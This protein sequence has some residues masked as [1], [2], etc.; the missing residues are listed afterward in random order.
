MLAHVRCCQHHPK[1]GRINPGT[2]CAPYL[3]S[4]CP[5]EGSDT[6]FHGQIVSHLCRSLSFRAQAGCRPAGG[7]RILSTASVKLPDSKESLAKELQALKVAAGDLAEAGTIA[8][9]PALQLETWP[10][11]LCWPC[12]AARR[13]PAL[14]LYKNMGKGS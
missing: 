6:S 8:C 9:G 4:L 1:T 11:S 10:R 14:R 13:P 2:L 3:T 5:L 12:R 7:R